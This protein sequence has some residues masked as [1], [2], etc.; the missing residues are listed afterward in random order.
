[1][2]RFCSLSFLVTV[3]VVLAGCGDS[4]P[5]SAI[6]TSSVQSAARASESSETSY[7]RI[8][9]TADRARA[10]EAGSS[11]DA[12]FRA[13]INLFDFQPNA[14][15]ES[16][17]HHLRLYATREE[18]KALS[19]TRPWAEAYYVDGVSHAY[20]DPSKANPYHWLLHEV[21]H[22]LNR[23]LTGYAKEQW[24]NEGLATYLGSS[25]YADG[26]LEP[27]VADLDAYPLWWLKRWELSGD[28][29]ADVQAQRVIPLRALITGQGGPPLDATVNAHYL[30]WWS[31]THFLL[32]HDGGRHAAGYHQLVRHGGS[33]ADFER[34]I[35]PLPQVE[36][37]WYAYLQAMVERHGRPEASEPASRP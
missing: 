33:L 22:Q 6:S 20:L 16:K 1:M 17:G 11:A 7:F 9:S 28:F 21:V 18:F 10:V 3:L 26:R 12:L 36:A 15:G 30:G 24:L 23:E 29:V 14:P 13:Y 31:L 27:G 19:R 32:H 34:H 8:E 37:E 4:D 35:G 25:R 2:K 5:I